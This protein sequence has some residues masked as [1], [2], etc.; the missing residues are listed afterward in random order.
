M[1]R[2]AIGL[3]A[4]LVGTAAY[5]EDKKTE[6]PSG[7]W[8]RQA[9]E[10]KVTIAFVKADKLKI[11]LDNDGVGLVV[12]AD[13]TV[14]KDGKLTATITG[15][16]KKG[17]FPAVPKAGDKFSLKLK[18][19]GEKATVSDFEA[20]EHEAAKKIFEGEYKKKPKD[21]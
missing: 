17:E 11:T 3:L 19:D 13:Y 1:H 6:G 2:I 5:A 7:T 8:V 10:F 20:G 9:D 18:A 14:D 16:E 4:A 12:E 21:D 15:A